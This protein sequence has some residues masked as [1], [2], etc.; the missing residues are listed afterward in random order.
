MIVSLC[1]GLLLFALAALV[2]SP[3]AAQQRLALER[4]Q[5]FVHP[6]SGIEVPVELGGIARSEALAYA[7]DQLDV[8]VAFNLINPA[9]ALTLYIFRNTNGSV[10]LWFAQ[11]Q[12]GLEGNGIFAGSTLAEPVRAF[13]PPGQRAGSGLRATYAVP[14]AWPGGPFQSTGLAMF[15]A[16][17]WFVKLRASSATRDTAGLSAW[18]DEVLAGLTVPAGTAP[19][20]IP[21]ADC[22]PRLSFRGIAGDADKDA[23]ADIFGSLIG[24]MVAERLASPRTQEAPPPVWCRDHRLEPTQIIYRPD[25]ARDAYLLALGD[26]GNGVLVGRDELAGLI[27]EEGATPPERSSI[28]LMTAGRA[29]S[30]V[31]QDR[32]PSAER[33]LDLIRDDRVVSST[34][35]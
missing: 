26:N 5:A 25:E 21:V 4:G 9:E 3:L 17:G 10:P 34:N 23:S 15:E 20:A 7:E 31:A 22:P 30:F 18:M 28:T 35:T 33:V 13:V 2:V 1:R 16:N 19:V 11:A 6:H 32:L 27:A 29:V 14:G 12:A 24:G 8:S